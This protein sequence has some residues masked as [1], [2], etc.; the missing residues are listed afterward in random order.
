M[1]LAT[2]NTNS[3]VRVVGIDDSGD[4]VRYI[5]IT[6]IDP[7]IPNSMRQILQQSNG[8]DKCRAA[9]DRGLQVD[10]SVAGTVLAPVPDPGK[11]LCIGLNYRDHAEETGAEI[12]GEPVCFGKFGNTII[13]TG[14]PIRLPKV[15]AKVDFEAELVVI[16]GKAGREI[17]QADAFGHI[18]GYCNGHDVSAR[19]WQIGK[20]GGQWLLG[21]TPDTFAPI[22]PW[23]V[24]SDEIADPHNLPISLKL[25]GEQMQSGNT[26]EFIFG[27]DEVIAYVSQIITLQPGDVIFTGTPPGVGMGRNPKVWLKPGD[28]VDIEIPGL[29]VLSNP[30]VQADSTQ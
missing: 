17:S 3:G 4:A 6:E 9:M 10:K 27:I 5:P 1:K 28:T 29:G 11:I 13:G 14:E 25:N 2:L 23:L 20:P 15:S 19:D 22:G 16:I 26:K 24:T 8:L 30:V 18:A 7:S 21:K 12:P